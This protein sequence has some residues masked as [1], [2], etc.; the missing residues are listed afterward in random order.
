MWSLLIP[1]LLIFVRTVVP[2]NDQS[3]CIDEKYRNF[4]IVPQIIPISPPEV[5]SDIFGDYASNFGNRIPTCATRTRPFT[6]WP[7]AN[8]NNLYSL[9]AI[10][11]DL[12]QF[13]TSTLG[14]Q[15]LYGLIVNIPGGDV[16][17]G[18]KLAPYVPPICIPGYRDFRF[19][20]LI[21]QQQNRISGIKQL[22]YRYSTNFGN[23]SISEFVSRYRLGNPIAG[24][25]FR[26]LC[27]VPCKIDDVCEERSCNKLSQSSNTC[28]I[29]AVSEP[30]KH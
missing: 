30:C 10:A 17:R 25:F 27:R 28:P 9:I 18:D 11:P 22:M 26:T 29:C 12:P 23:F 1:T 19:V 6:T 7:N 14:I 4:M 16:E 21:Y 15:S 20:C 24:N 3:D 8:E 5:V 2:A 13:Y